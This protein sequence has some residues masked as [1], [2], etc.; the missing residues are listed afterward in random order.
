MC[1]AYEIRCQCGKE[2]ARVHHANSILPAE[3][4]ENIHCPDCSRQVGFESARMLRDN[5]WII[6]YDMDVVRLHAEKLGLSHGEITPEAV[7]DGGFSSWQGF[8]PNDLERANAEKQ[9]L[10]ELAAQDMKQYLK[11]IREWSIVRERK[12]HHEGWRKARGAVK[13]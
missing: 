13:A 8:T 5:G 3:T 12:L 11:A 2:N 4:I 9:E 7:F 6:A 10:A 1:T